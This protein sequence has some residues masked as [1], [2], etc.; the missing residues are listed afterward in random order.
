MS[1]RKVS[2]RRSNR[3]RTRWAVVCAGLAVSLTVG[4]Q[5]AAAASGTP[6]PPRPPGRVLAV[7]AALAG[8]L[9]HPDASPAGANDW[10]CRPTRKHPRPVVLLHGSAANAYNNWSMLSPWLKR[11]GYCVFAPNYGGAPGSPFKAT[12]PIPESARQVA[13]YVDRVLKATGARQV[14]LVGHSQ[15]GGPT[16]RWYLRFEGGTD[17]A[18]PKRN[19]VRS[20]IAL[21]PSNHGGTVSGIGTLTTK[22]GLNPTVS[23]VVGQAWSDQMVGSEMNRKLDRGGDTQPGVRYTVIATRYDEFATPYHNSFLTAGPGAT[24]K[25][26][27]IQDVCPQDVSE[28]LSLAYDSNA[29]QLVSNALDPAHAQPVRCGLSLPV[30]G[31]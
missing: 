7:P 29:A 11:Q 8:G 16:P 30:L 2:R 26:I 27:L 18:H 24:V 9:V 28:H 22:L 19:K 10:S 5:G 4:L 14:D 23:A 15:G 13:G 12:G 20:L 17:P 3:Q 21:A 1:E 31:G 25:N 6:V